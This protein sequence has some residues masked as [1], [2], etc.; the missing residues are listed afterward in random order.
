MNTAKCL[1]YAMIVGFLSLVGGAFYWQIGQREIL[2]AHPA[3]PHVQHQRRWVKRGGILD[4]RGE[5]IADSVEEPHGFRRVYLG[6]TGLAPTMGYYSQ[7]YGTAGVEKT[8]DRILMGQEYPGTSALGRAKHA[9]SERTHGYNLITTVDL[10]F[11]KTVEQILGHSPGAAIVMEVKTGRI[12]AVASTPGFMPNDIDDHW[13]EISTN[14]GSPLYNRA[15]AG[16]YPP[17]STF[18]LVVLA[19]GLSS[20]AANLQSMFNDTGTTKVQGYKITNAGNRQW[21]QISLLDALVISSNVVFV[22]LG[23]KVGPKSLLEMA[24]GFGIGR[25]P[26]LVAD[27]IRAGKLPGGNISDLQ[28]AQM[29]IGQYGLITTPLQLTILAQTIA[30]DGL[31]MQPMLIDAVQDGKSGVRWNNAP[32]PLRQVVTAQVARE[33][34][35]AMVAVVDRGTGQQAALAE[36]KVAGKTGSAENPQ[37]P[38]HAWFVGMAPSLQP[39][40]CLAVIVENSGSGGSVAAPLAREIFWAYFSGKRGAPSR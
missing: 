9:L 13:Q 14:S 26:P 36:I 6:T 5:V 24:D 2:A 1:R 38:A 22:E 17:G 39:E 3:N 40:I 25:Q 20:G 30:N 7:R 21:G 37:G 27:N 18:K 16:F 12:L 28:L 19:A 35:E 33:M 11:Q 10:A 32:Q 8:F 31:M 4:I 15:F 34:R 23:R 29:C